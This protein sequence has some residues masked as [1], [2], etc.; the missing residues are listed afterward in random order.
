M[1]AVIIYYSRSGNTERIA[2][3]LQADLGEI[4]AIKIVP[5]EA[6]GNYIMSCL[7]VMKENRTKVIPKFTTPIPDLSE[8]D[9]IFLGFPIW[10]QDVPVFVQEFIRQ[11]DTHGKAIIPFATYGM[12]GI[13]WTKKTLHSLFDPKQI[14]LP[15]DSG[16]LKKGDYKKWISEIKKL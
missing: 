1:N 14:R 6:Y 4:P 11:C 5:E 8:Y 7:R 9:T 13:R 3:Q 15:F 12:S 16:V 10:A 2:K